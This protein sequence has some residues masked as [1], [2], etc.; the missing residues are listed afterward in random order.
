MGGVWMDVGVTGGATRAGAGPGRAGLHEA[1]GMREQ[2]KKA[3]TTEEGERIAK[4]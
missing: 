3:H 4:G 2:S 1:N